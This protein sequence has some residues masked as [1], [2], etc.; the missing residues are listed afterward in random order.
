MSNMSDEGKTGTEF[1][2]QFR[3]EYTAQQNQIES[4]KRSRSTW[5]IG[6][7]VVV[8]V[9][10][11]MVGGSAC[12]TYNSLTDKQVTVKQKWADVDTLLQSRADL[13]PNLVNTVKGYAK[14]EEKVFGDIAAARS[15]LLNAQTPDAKGEANAELSSALGRLL[16]ITENYPDLK[17]NDQFKMLQVQLEGTERRIA[18]ARQDYNGVVAD[19]NR[20]RQRFPTV[21]TASMLGFGPEQEFK[22]DPGAR[23][24]PK[25]DFDPNK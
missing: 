12:S 4:R 7:A 20:T 21:L 22:A 3:Q 1:R 16:V 15:R 6:G 17:A 9:L 24:A 10:F 18:V 25:V 11:L 13:I 2:D 5:L 19:Y 23:D 14:H 8:L